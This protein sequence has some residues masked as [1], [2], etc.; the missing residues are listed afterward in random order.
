VRRELWPWNAAAQ[1]EIMAEAVQESKRCVPERFTKAEQQ[2]SN[3]AAPPER[4]GV[5]CRSQS[6][7]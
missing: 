1:P 4:E 2:A 3:W 6:E 7:A 5:E